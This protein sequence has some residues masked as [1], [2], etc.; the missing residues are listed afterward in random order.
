MD[1]YYAVIEGITPTKNALEEE[2]VKQPVLAVKINSG[3]AVRV[4]SHILGELT[5]VDDFPFPGEIPQRL[6]MSKTEVKKQVPIGRQ[7]HVQNELHLRKFEGEIILEDEAKLRNAQKINEMNPFVPQSTEPER[8][9]R[10]ALQAP[11]ALPKKSLT[12]EQ[13]IW[14]DAYKAQYDALGSPDDQATDMVH[15]FNK[16]FPGVL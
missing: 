12:L 5:F 4:Y 16:R 2:L 8:I 3:Y 7:R 10:Q 9:Q 6:I 14:W 13:Q 1:Y 11:I 15:A